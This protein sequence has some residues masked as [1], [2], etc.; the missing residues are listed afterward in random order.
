MKS[1][2]DRIKEL[3]AEFLPEVEDFIDFLLKKNRNK[4]KKKPAFE[5][6]GALEDL[7]EEYTSVELQHEISRFRATEK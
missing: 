6:V 7:K 5:W 4:K 3:P 1:L 2:E